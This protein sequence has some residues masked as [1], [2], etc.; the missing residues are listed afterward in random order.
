MGRTS[1][2][3]VLDGK[4]PRFT[5]LKL[6]RTNIV[7]VPPRMVLQYSSVEE[8]RKKAGKGAQT[9]PWTLGVH[10]VHRCTPCLLCAFAAWSTPLN[11]SSGREGCRSARRQMM[12]E[13][14]RL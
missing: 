2:L 10:C 8:K 14:A 3:D 11:L 13:R 9:S 1:L 4:Q 12:G 5:S 7:R 6:R